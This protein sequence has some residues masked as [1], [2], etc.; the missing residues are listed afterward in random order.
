MSNVPPLIPP[1]PATSSPAAASP[2]RR[3]AWQHA[4]SVGLVA[5]VSAFVGYVGQ[6]NI[7]G[8]GKNWEP[9]V[10][11]ALV[12]AAGAVWHLYTPSPAPAP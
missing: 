7:D 3:P 11:G 5:A 2:P 12:A 6:H 1:P 4:L 8:G 10:L 9:I